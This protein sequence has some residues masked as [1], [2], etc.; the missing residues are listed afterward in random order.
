MV[1]LSGAAAAG[2]G[3]GVVMGW[4]RV[5]LGGGGGRGTHGAH[6]RTHRYICTHIYIYRY[7]CM[8]CNAMQCNVM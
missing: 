5:P 1:V 6:I 2:A 3:A 4:W 7:M 8:Q